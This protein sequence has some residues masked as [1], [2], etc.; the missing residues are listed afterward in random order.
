MSYSVSFAKQYSRSVRC[1]LQLLTKLIFNPPPLTP[2]PILHGFIRFGLF[3]GGAFDAEGR[4]PSQFATPFHGHKGLRSQ[5]LYVAGEGGRGVGVS[6]SLLYPDKSVIK[7]FTKLVFR[8]GENCAAARKY[9][10]IFNKGLVG[11]R[12]NHLLPWS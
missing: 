9:I 6:I 1:W 3:G 4:S 12:Y 8:C 11:L 5:I 7:D 10:C 2:P